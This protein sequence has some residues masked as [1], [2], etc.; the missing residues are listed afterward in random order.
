LTHKI[1]FITPTSFIDVSVQSQKSER[2]CMCL[3]YAEYICLSGTCESCKLSNGRA[4]MD[5]FFM[6]LLLFYLHHPPGDALLLNY[7]CLLLI[8]LKDEYCLNHKLLLTIN[9]LA[10]YRSAR[11]SE[12][13]RHCNRCDCFLH[14]SIFRYKTSPQ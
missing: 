10:K 5:S 2:P 11:G 13:N 3:L 6:F 12:Y 9:S 7:M 4:M 1:S 8:L 14:S